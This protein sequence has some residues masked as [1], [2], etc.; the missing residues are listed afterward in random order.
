MTNVTVELTD[1]DLLARMRNFE[2]HLS[3]AENCQ[4]RKGLEKDRSCILR[5]P[6][7]SAFLPCFT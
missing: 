4:G 6:F 1:A 3:R 2:D 7:Q 5:I